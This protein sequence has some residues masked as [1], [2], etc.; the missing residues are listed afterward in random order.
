MPPP[1]ADPFAPVEE[2]I[3][4]ATG[5]A[6]NSKMFELMAARGLR[7]GWSETHTRAAICGLI[8]LQ[9]DRQPTAALSPTVARWKIG[10]AGRGEQFFGGQ[11]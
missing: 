3:R 1:D 5:A 4:A 7:E 8:G 9:L 10:K 11:S 6:K 2:R